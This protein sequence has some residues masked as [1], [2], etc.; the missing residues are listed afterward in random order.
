MG[1]KNP[2]RL[3]GIHVET[4][5]VCWKQWPC[6]WYRIPSNTL[7]TH[8]LGGLSGFNSLRSLMFYVHYPEFLNYVGN[9]LVIHVVVKLKPILYIPLIILLQVIWRIDKLF[10][11]IFYFFIMKSYRLSVEKTA[12]PSEL[13]F[14][15][16]P[17]NTLSFLSQDER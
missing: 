1:L 14:V 15:G 7:M 17:T 11:L 16:L 2:N 8:W 12:S 4:I 3:K 9:N 10:L 6:L 5:N 13:P